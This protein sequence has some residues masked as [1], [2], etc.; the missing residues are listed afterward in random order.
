MTDRR[1]GSK[2]GPYVAKEPRAR[3]KDGSWRRKRSDAGK[4]QSIS[5][6][7]RRRWCRRMRPRASSPWNCSSNLS[8]G[9][10]IYSVW[11]CPSGDSSTCLS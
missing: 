10:S 6:S 1:A 8:N 4:R 5:R 11:I 7:T 9:S 3:N 2:Q